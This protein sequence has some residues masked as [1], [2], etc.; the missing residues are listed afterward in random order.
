[1]SRR[2]VS[3]TIYITPEQQEALKVQNE[4]TK[5]PIAQPR[6]DGARLMVGFHYLVKGLQ[7]A[8]VLALVIG[9]GVPFLLAPCIAALA[10]GMGW[11]R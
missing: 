9:V 2:K 6:R 10:R 7:D 5:V 4:R 8:G 3:T 11:T 1:M